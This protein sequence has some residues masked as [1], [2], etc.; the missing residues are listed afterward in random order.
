MPDPMLESVL[1]GYGGALVGAMVGGIFDHYLFNL[2]YPHM[3][4]LFWMFIGLGVATTRFI[5]Q[6]QDALQNRQ[7]SVSPESNMPPRQLH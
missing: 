6:R 7:L 3:S 4:T 1:L 2:V 5:G